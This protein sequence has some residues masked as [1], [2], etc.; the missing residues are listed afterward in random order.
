MTTIVSHSEWKF[1]KFLY[2]RH[3]KNLTKILYPNPKG[4][5]TREP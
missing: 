5:K 3:I 4:E 1:S 2:S